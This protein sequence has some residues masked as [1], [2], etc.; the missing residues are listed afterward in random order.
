[1]I[2]IIEE[3]QPRPQGLLSIFQKGGSLHRVTSHFEKYPE[4]PGDEVGGISYDLLVS[5]W[6][7][8]V[9]WTIRIMRPVIV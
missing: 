2:L 9:E 5:V 7:P 6:V 3:F 4:G 1:M 8:E